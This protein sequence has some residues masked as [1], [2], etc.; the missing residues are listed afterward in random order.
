MQFEHWVI[1]VRTCSWIYLIS[2]KE[3]LTDMQ[4]YSTVNM[5]SITNSGIRLAPWFLQILYLIHLAPWCLQ[6]DMWSTWHLGFSSF[7][8][9]SAWQIKY[10][11]YKKPGKRHVF[12][13]FCTYICMLC[14]FY[15]SC[16]IDVVWFYE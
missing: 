5:C 4:K 12:R 1:L 2:L 3:R 6:I 14:L 11:Y 7:D 13:T 15:I 8:I 10:H 16:T 9:W